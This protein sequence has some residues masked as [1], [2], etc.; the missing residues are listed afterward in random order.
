VLDPKHFENCVEKG[1]Q[2]V[3]TFL[4]MAGV[5]ATARKHGSTLQRMKSFPKRIGAFCMVASSRC[6]FRFDLTAGPMIICVAATIFAISTVSF[7]L[8]RVGM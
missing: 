2:I 1:E 4:R 7:Q 6:V 8:R 3:L 5:A